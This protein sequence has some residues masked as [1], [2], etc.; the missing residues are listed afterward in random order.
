M[1]RQITDQDLAD[2]FNTPLSEYQHRYIMPTSTTT[3]TTTTNCD[4]SP[5]TPNDERRSRLRKLRALMDDFI[6]KNRSND[7]VHFRVQVLKQRHGGG[8][9]QSWPACTLKEPFCD[10]DMISN[11]GL[12][13]TIDCNVV[14]CALCMQSK[15]Y[16]QMRIP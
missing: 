9:L 4:D 13:S 14:D 7:H 15:P 11:M 5:Q 16:K 12:R 8:T 10:G 3:S 2:I 6:M 1:P